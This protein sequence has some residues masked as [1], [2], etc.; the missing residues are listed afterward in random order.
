[1]LL[2]LSVL[3]F[4]FR[5]KSTIAMIYAGVLVSLSGAF[6]LLW[7]YG[8]PWFLNLSIGGVELREVFHIE[9]VKL[10]VAVWVGMIALLGIATDDGVVMASALEGRLDRSEPSSLE[11]LRSMVLE[12]AGARLI[13]CLMTTATTLIALLPVLTSAGRGADVMRPMALPSIGGMCLELLTLFVVPTL[14]YWRERRLLNA[15]KSEIKS[16]D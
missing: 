10:S 5:R 3:N 4:Q 14:F 11:E 8:Q 12:E 6:I 9:P 13:P 15:E 1:M 2:I 16:D 7:C